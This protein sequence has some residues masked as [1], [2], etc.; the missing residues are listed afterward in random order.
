MELDLGA[1][2]DGDVIRNVGEFLKKY[3]GKGA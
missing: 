3:S 1:A 2:L